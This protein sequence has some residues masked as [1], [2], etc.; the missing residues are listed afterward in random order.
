VKQWRGRGRQK[1]RRGEAAERR[2]Q[3]AHMRH[4]KL[5]RATAGHANDAYLNG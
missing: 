4:S 5:N 3:R 2:E 1:A